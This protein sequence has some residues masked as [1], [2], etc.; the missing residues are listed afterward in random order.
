MAEEKILTLKTP[1]LVA[2]DLLTLRPVNVDDAE[3]YLQL[4]AENYD[5]LS[6]WHSAP[7][8]SNLADERRK[9]M[10]EDLKS[11]ENGK[12]HWWLIESSNDVAGTIALHS[13]QARDRSALVGYWL[14][15]P[16]VGRG[17]MT[18]SLRAAI[19]WAFNELGLIRVE[20][21]CALINRASCAVPERLGIR[22]ESIRRQSQIRNGEILDMASYVAL[23]DNWSSK[24]TGQ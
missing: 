5:R 6:K 10:A 15:E 20:I 12:A 16:H 21:Q 9:Y 1:V 17:I 22:R 14:A 23:A 8:P 24:S 13:I 19:D 4:V 2:G 7:R 3:I 11:G 18:A